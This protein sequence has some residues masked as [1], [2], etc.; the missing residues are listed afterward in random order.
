MWGYT[1]ACQGLTIGVTKLHLHCRA[2]AAARSQQHTTEASLA[3]FATA[4]YWSLSPLTPLL[5]TICSAMNYNCKRHHAPHRM[6]ENGV[7]CDSWSGFTAVIRRPI[8]VNKYHLRN[9]QVWWSKDN[10]QIQ[11][12]Q[13]SNT[14]AAWTAVTRQPTTGESLQLQT[15]SMPKSHLQTHSMIKNHVPPSSIQTQPHSSS[16]LLD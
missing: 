10:G 2:A 7:T 6:N 12:K 5:T 15:D 8:C 1:H 16:D 3:F 11:H 4:T 14:P 9:Q 13:Q